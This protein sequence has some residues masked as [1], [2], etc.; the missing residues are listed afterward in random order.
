MLIALAATLALHPALAPRAFVDQAPGEDPSAP[1]RRFPVSILVH[2]QGV[3]LQDVSMLRLASLQARDEVEVRVSDGLTRDWTFAA[4][5]LSAGQKPKVKSWNLWEKQWKNHPIEVGAVPDG[6]VVP[7]FFLVLNRRKDGRVDDALQRAL[8][9]NSEQV[10]SA[11]SVFETTYHQTN[12]LLNFIGAYSELG[13]YTSATCLYQS[14][15]NQLRYDLGLP[16]DATLDKTQP[17]EMRQSMALGMAALNAV[18]KSPDDP[19]AAAMIVK[20]QLPGPIGDWLGLATDLVHIFIR[21]RKDLKVLLVPSSASESTTVQR[22]GDWMDLVTERVLET[23]DDSIPG[24]VYRPGYVRSDTKT[25]P[26]Q[27]DRP[28]VVAP[29]KEVAIPIGANSRDLFNS[30]TAW[31]WQISTDGLNFTPLAGAKLVPGRGLVFPI[32]DKWWDGANEKKIWIRTNIA[33]Q[34]ATSAP[35]NVARAYPQDWVADGPNDL[36]VGDNATIKLR[37]SGG[38]AQPYYTYAGAT[39]TDSTGKIIQ[40]TQVGQGNVMTLSFPLASAAPGNAIVRV[41]QDGADMSDGPITVFVAPKRPL[42]TFRCAKGDNILT[43]DGPDAPMVKSIVVPSRNVVRTEAAANNQSFTFSDRLPQDLSSV[44]VTYYDPSRP[45]LE[46]KRT[47]PVSFGSPR[48]R[49]SATLVGSLPEQ[50]GIGTGDDPNWAMATMPVGWFRTKQPIR[51]NLNAVAPFAWGHDV[52]LS[53]GFGSAND[54]QSMLNLPEGQMFTI[55]TTIPSSSITVSLEDAV[56]KGSARNNGLVWL[57]LTRGDLNSGWVLVKSADGD[58]GAPLRAVKLP[59]V[60]SVDRND[61]RT[62]VT[63]N[64][65]DYVT[66]AKFGNGASLMPTLLDNNPQTGLTAYVDGPPNSNEFDLN[67]RDAPEGVVHVKLSK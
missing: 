2:R 14:N 25:I 24:L 36:A 50:V 27:F 65:A 28:N 20:N 17:A 5:Y 37:R 63:F 34:V 31:G 8:E 29:A 1:L 52:A 3:P 22:D 53:L 40:S 42:V 57:K 60:V 55:D 41:Q 38:V 15:I 59:N 35:V 43:A 33:F 54:V 61:Q 62:R 49:F 46:W 11:T 6:D 13:P 12:R 67:L 56:P 19:A 39:L 48:P 30:P 9:S 47:E 45:N 18:R 32:N 7:L 4:A 23:N 64:M 16:V 10:V 51:V 58:A 26:L 66:G 44:D 21:P